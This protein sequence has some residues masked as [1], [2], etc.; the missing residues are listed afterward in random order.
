MSETTDGKVRP[1][2]PGEDK[3]IAVEIMDD[4]GIESMTLIE[5]DA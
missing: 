2:E 4:R 3:R 1:F 5:V